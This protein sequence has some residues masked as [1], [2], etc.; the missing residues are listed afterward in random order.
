MNEDIF[1]S[2]FARQLAACPGCIM[3]W[4][5]PTDADDV[6]KTIFLRWRR[7]MRLQTSLF[8][9]NT[10][11]LLRSQVRIWLWDTEFSPSASILH[12][13]QNHRFLYAG[14][15]PH[16]FFVRW[17]V[18]KREIPLRRWLN[19]N[20]FRTCI[21]QSSGQSSDLI[22]PSNH[23]GFLRQLIHAAIFDTNLQTKLATDGHVRNL[24]VILDSQSKYTISESLFLN[25]PFKTSQNKI[26]NVGII[27]TSRGQCC[28]V[29]IYIY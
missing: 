26:R 21:A 27:E 29:N 6:Q 16:P 11:S 13:V 10:R 15:I 5:T 28:V 1:A 17:S 12:G 7:Q 4:R 20:V 19:P 24:F 18:W 2:H 8:C 25:C 22:A 23:G 14:F 3:I 9:V